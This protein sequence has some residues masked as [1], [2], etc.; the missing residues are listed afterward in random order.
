MSNAELREIRTAV[1]AL[2][3]CHIQDAPTVKKQDLWYK[4]S[5]SKNQV[6]SYLFLAYKPK[7]Q[8]Y[9]VHAG[10]ASR[11]ARL[12]VFAALD[13]IKEF[14]DPIYF[15]DSSYM[16]RPCWHMFDAGRALD[17]SSVY[18]IPDPFDR[19]NWRNRFD[20]LINGFLAMHING[21]NNESKI[22][23]L[24]LKNVAPF[25]WSLSNPVLRISEIVSMA[26]AS[27][28][29]IEEL[30]LKA[31]LLQH[32]ISRSLFGPKSYANVMRSIVEVLY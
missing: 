4:R 24:L 18:V 29:S 28:V 2:G 15:A 23:D 27:G 3:Y 9:S 26:R 12:K 11:D 32:D 22:I 1:E 16:E 25:E 21:I 19:S 8:A 14:A 30:M 13:S 20:D 6:D 7:A 10:V 17:W 31:S 5:T